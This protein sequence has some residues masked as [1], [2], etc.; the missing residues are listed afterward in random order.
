MEIEWQD[1][2]FLE[3]IERTGSVGAASRELGLSSS[4][5]YRRIAALEE[6]AGALC[7]QRGA[8]SG[9]VALTEVGLALAQVARRTHKGISDVLGQVRARETEVAGEVSLT[10]VDALL[11]FLIEPIRDL[12]T[13]YP[14]RLVL[15]L[16]NSGPSVRDREVDIAIGIMPRPPSG[17]WGV[18]LGKIPYAVFG[19]ADA[20]SREPS[21]KWVTRT[22]DEQHS[23]ESKWEREHAGEIAA[24][25]PFNSL[26]S[27]V[28]S[29]VGIGL[30]PKVIASLHPQLVEIGSYRKAVSD[31]ERTAW[32]L[33]H[34]DLRGTPRVRVVLDALRS[35][36]R[37]VFR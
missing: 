12:T 31:L 21:P 18:R 30:I 36:F 5:L 1:V 2:R 33:T 14:L 8:T 27:L 32:L 35:R 13:Q 28:A 19:T 15:T 17:C 37:G 26:V 25:A 9:S 29:G 6:A 22:V 23:P 10:T 16:A 20:L 3:V 24:S 7:L 4:T 34:P 11:P